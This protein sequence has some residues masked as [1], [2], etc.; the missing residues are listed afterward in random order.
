[1]LKDNK[2]KRNVACGLVDPTRSGLR[3]VSRPRARCKTNLAIG[4]ILLGM[5]EPL[6]VAVEQVGNLQLKTSVCGHSHLLRHALTSGS[7]PTQ[8]CTMTFRHWLVR[9]SHPTRLASPCKAQH[10]ICPRK[11]DELSSSFLPLY[12]YIQWRVMASVSKSNL[13]CWFLPSLCFR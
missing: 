3:S 7:D 11:Y 2:R 1:M 12:H 5:T 10:I 9:A 4:A 13:V 8:P 6:Y